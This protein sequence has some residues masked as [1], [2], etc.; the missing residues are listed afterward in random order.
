VL[1]DGTE[2]KWDIQWGSPSQLQRAA[3]GQYGTVY[4]EVGRVH[5]IK[6]SPHRTES[7]NAYMKSIVLPNGDE[8]FCC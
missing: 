4:W 6:A 5:H 3:A 7:G 8:F 1:P 2:K